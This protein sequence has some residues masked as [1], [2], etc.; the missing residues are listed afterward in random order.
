MVTAYLERQRKRWPGLIGGGPLPEPCDA[1]VKGRVENFKERHRTGRVDPEPIRN[2]REHCKLLGD[3]Y[4]RYSC[5]NSSPTSIVDR[6]VNIL[7]K[8]HTEGRFIPWQYLFAD[9]SITGLDPSRQ[10]Y[11][12]YKAVLAD[13]K[14]SI[15]T[16]YIDDFSRASRD[17]LEW[18]RLA[19]LSKRLRKRMDLWRAAQR[20]LAV[21]RRA[22]PLTGRKQSRNEKFPTTLFSGTLFC[23]H[24]RD[25]MLGDGEIKLIRSTPKYKQ[26]GCLNGILGLHDCPLCTSKSTQIIEECLLGAICR[27]IL[28]EDVIRKRIKR[29][30]AAGTRELLIRVPSGLTQPSTR[31]S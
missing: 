16:T 31:G 7:D 19:A 12:S 2:F 28:T 8:A 11:S 18:W 9:Y 27:G 13:E 17:E 30:N 10:G 25:H 22:S 6:M 29:S 14:H 4:E 23:Q 21:M 24:C 5:D 1:I 20:K 15:E 3:A 26:M